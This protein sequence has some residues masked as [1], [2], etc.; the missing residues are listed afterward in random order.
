MQGLACGACVAVAPAA[1]GFLAALLAP[2]ILALLVER[3]PGRPVARGVLL[4]GAAASVGPL[5]TVWHMGM[6]T[7]YAILSDP[8]VLG[9]AWGACAGGWVMSQLLPIGI[10]GVLEATSLSRAAALRAEREKL[11]KAWGLD[12]H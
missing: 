8:G 3:T 5:M 1:C 4:C 10:R 11:L 9:A 7:G 2:A 6:G 12:D